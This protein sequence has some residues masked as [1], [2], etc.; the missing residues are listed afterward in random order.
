MVRECFPEK[1]TNFSVDLEMIDSTLG[2][3]E[4]SERYRYPSLLLKPHLYYLPP[5]HKA[6]LTEFCWISAMLTLLRAT[7]NHPGSWPQEMPSIVEE[8]RFMLIHWYLSHKL[9][10]RLRN[11]KTKQSSQNKNN[12]KI[13]PSIIFTLTFSGFPNSGPPA[14]LL[15]PVNQESTPEGHLPCSSW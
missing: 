13:I 1:E 8:I 6:P 2:D 10:V 5:C 4:K 9:K 15:W 7:E 3:T 12:N 14:D 11:T